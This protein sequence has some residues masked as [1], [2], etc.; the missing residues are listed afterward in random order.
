MDRKF[1]MIY[2]W[3]HLVRDDGANIQRNMST[4]LDQKVVTETSVEEPIL[5]V[6]LAIHPDDDAKVRRKIDAHMLPLM[7][8]IYGLQFVGILFQIQFD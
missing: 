3:F 6:P 4:K 1:V 7:C 2:T 8:A 5:N